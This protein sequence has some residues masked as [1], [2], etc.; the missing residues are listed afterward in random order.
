MRWATRYLEATTLPPEQLL[1]GCA[2]F[3]FVRRWR[4]AR[5]ALARAWEAEQLPD[6]PIP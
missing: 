6:P 5:P 4:R 3:G 2:A 1:T